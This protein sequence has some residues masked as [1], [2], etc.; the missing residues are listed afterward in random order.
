MESRS[1]VREPEIAACPPY[2]FLSTAIEIPLLARLINTCEIGYFS[3]FSLAGG[4][5]L[6]LARKYTG[7]RHVQHLEC[8]LE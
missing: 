8:V 2:W 4:V 3:C 1:L 5:A 6:S 7:N